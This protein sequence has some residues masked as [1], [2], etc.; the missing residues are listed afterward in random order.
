MQYFCMK[1]EHNYLLETNNLTQGIEKKPFDV[2]KM[3]KEFMQQKQNS[4]YKK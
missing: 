4:M 3:Q 1:M 2:C